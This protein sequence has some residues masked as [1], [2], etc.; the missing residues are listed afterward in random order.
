[1]RARFA[2]VADRELRFADPPERLREP[3]PDLLLGQLDAPAA[4]LEPAEDRRQVVARGVD[5]VARCRELVGRADAIAKARRVD[6]RDRTVT[7]RS[8]VKLVVLAAVQQ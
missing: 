2:A 6:E 1:M 5:Q 3:P 4:Q 8:Q 7:A